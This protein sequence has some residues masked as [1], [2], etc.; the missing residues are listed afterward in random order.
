MRRTI[1]VLSLLGLLL[2]LNGRAAAQDKR[3]DAAFAFPRQVQL[4]DDQKA[5]LENLKKEYGP[6][7]AEAD[8]RV[9][10][11]MTPE[12]QKAAAEVRK[13]ATSEGKKGKDVQDAVNAA[14]NLSADEQAKFREA[15][16]A[17][18]KLAQEINKKK[19][20]LLTEEQKA[21]LKPKK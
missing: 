16:A 18:A 10:G 17:R 6:K 19:L 14:L 1:L 8:T 2:L 12:R 20:E 7:L 9:T 15:T 4:T 11:V 5:K 13:K 3:I 21:Q